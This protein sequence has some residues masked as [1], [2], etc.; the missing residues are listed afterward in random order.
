MPCQAKVIAS[1]APAGTPPSSSIMI[2]AVYQLGP[3]KT[4]CLDSAAV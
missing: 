4:Y 3:D 1:F 2:L